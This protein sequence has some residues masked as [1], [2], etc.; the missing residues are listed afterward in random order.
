[1][2]VDK[3]YQDQITLENRFQALQNL[4]TAEE[5][6]HSCIESHTQG[7]IEVDFAGN[8]KQEQVSKQAANTL[9]KTSS[10]K[11][12]FHSAKNNTDGAAIMANQKQ[13]LVG[14]KNKFGSFDGEGNI[15]SMQHDQEHMNNIDLGTA[16]D[17]KFYHCHEETQDLN[18][19]I[20]SGYTRS[21]IL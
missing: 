15:R 14:N 11:E 9:Q 7:N 20:S 6:R 21:Y 5:S 3:Q 4:E 16:Y 2:H 19:P 10:A 1:M 8:A 17:I 12:S 18:S 13:S